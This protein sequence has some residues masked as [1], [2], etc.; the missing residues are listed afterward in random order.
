VVHEDE[1]AHEDAAARM[2]RV[3]SVVDAAAEMTVVSANQNLIRR[4]SVSDV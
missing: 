3:E 4:L 2:T 1:E